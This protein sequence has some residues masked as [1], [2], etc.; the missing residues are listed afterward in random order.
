M[1]DLEYSR[2][3]K[4]LKIQGFL[5]SVPEM[6]DTVEESMVQVESFKSCTR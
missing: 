3:M 6:Y 5:S 4:K 2:T 1:L